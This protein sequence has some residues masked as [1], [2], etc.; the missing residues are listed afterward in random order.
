MPGATRSRSNEIQ[1]AAQKLAAAAWPMI[2]QMTADARRPMLVGLYKQLQS[3][4]GIAYDTSRRHIAKA[5]RIIRGQHVAPDGGHRNEITPEEQLGSVARS[6]LSYTHIRKPHNGNGRGRQTRIYAADVD[7][8]AETGRQLAEMI[9]A[10][11]NG[12]LRPIINDD[13]PF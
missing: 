10:H 4:E 11:L 9:I 5:L 12:E 3:D 6:L 2:D 1:A 8:I 7:T 13:L